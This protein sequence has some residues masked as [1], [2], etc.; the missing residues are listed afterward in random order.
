MVSQELSNKE[1]IHFLREVE[2]GITGPDTMFKPENETKELPYVLLRKDR[3]DVLR[4]KMH[5]V[6]ARLGG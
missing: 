1:L 3:A 4:S 2:S 6:V 5:K